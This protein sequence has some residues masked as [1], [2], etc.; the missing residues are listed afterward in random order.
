MNNDVRKVLYQ[1]LKT[2][3]IDVYYEIAPDDAILPYIVYSSPTD[4][5]VY[6]NQ[7]VSDV[8]IDIYDA[9]R[10]GYNVAVEIDNYLKEV[11]SLLDYKSFAEGNSSFWFKRTSRQA[12]PFSEDSNIWARQL[13]FETRIYRS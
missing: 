10:D 5:R 11:E 9:E 1:L 8:Q 12:I 4:G 3:G 13:V 7:V 6:K 2:L